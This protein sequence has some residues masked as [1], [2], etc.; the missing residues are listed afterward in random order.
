MDELVAK[1]ELAQ[2]RVVGCIYLII[3]LNSRLQ[4]CKFGSKFDR[5]LK[6]LIKPCGCEKLLLNST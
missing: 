2:T 1:G 5:F 4:N 3:A 6:R